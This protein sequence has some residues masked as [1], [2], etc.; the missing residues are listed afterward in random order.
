MLSRELGKAMLARRAGKVIF[1]SSILGSQ[2]GVTVPGYASAKSAVNGLT[3]ALANEW[4]GTGVNVNSIAPGL[5]E[6][7]L[8]SALIENPKVYEGFK[9]THPMGRH[10]Q[11]REM[12]GAALYLASDASSFTTGEIIV[13]DGGAIA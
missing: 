4:S 10:G 12:A 8:A 2:G 3:K 11:P 13:C 1:V 7:R 5:V 9:A 6:T